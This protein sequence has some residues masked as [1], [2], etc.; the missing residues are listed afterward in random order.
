MT[1]FT[2]LLMSQSRNCPMSVDLNAMQTQNPAR[3]QRFIN[4]ESF[5]TNDINNQSGA[6]YRLADPNG[7]IIIPV[8][9]HMCYTAMKLKALA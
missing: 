8:V 6:S 7:I 3:Y 5:T 9:V 1:W 2:F 4:L